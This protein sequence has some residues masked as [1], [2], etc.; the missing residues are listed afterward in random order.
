MGHNGLSV[1]FAK[2]AADRF[3]QRH[4]IAIERGWVV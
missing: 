4:V 1:S 2:G 3:Q